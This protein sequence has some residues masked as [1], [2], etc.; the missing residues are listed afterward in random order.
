MPNPYKNYGILD[1]LSDVSLSDAM[2]K[3][4]GELGLPTDY[5]KHNAYYMNAENYIKDKY[6]D[7]YKEVGA[8]QSG[9]QM[10][11]MLNFIGGYDWAARRNDPEN[12]VRMGRAYQYT[13]VSADPTDAIGDFRE[14]EV[15]ARF[16]NPESGRISNDDLIKAAYEFSRAADREDYSDFQPSLSA[17]ILGE[18][19]KRSRK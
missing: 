19:F 2:S 3:M 9:N 8:R 14:N 17:S 5:A 10:D 6:P 4:G 11:K 7:I 15:G 12:A 13:D 18:I 16:Y 1:F